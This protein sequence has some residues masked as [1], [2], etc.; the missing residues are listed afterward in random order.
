MKYLFIITPAIFFI[1]FAIVIIMIIKASKGVKSTVLDVNYVDNSDEEFEKVYT[2]IVN[3]ADK[4]NL[5]ELKEQ[6]IIEHKK[7]MKIIGAVITLIL[8]TFFLSIITPILSIIGFVA[9][10]V[11]FIKMA[12]D[13]KS[14]ISAYTAKYKDTVVKSVLQHFESNSN[15]IPENG[16]SSG[17]YR[18]SK[19]EGFDRFYSDDLMTGTLKNNCNFTMADVY[20]Q[21]ESTDSDGHTSYSDLFKGIYAIIQTPK[22]FNDVIYIKKDRKN[23]LSFSSYGIIGGYSSFEKISLDSLEFE[24]YFDVST[25]NKIV[26]MQLLTSDVMQMLV[27]FRE[28]MGIRYEM[29]IRDSKIYI[30]FFSDAMFET[31]SYKVDALDKNTMY[32]YYLMLKFIFDISYKLTNLIQNTEY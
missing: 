16:I 21:S 5:S 17:E 14:G 25:S 10:I 11:C 6:A 31:P 32:K 26:T 29:A 18:E 19:F 3:N 4:N 1:I 2:E 7:Q 30:R 13:K 8:I 15:Y 24:K 9:A 27:E 28:K 23:E 20:T 22:A 12:S